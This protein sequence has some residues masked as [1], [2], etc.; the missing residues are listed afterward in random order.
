[1][2]AVRSKELN[3]AH[4]K[5][6]VLFKIKR[7]LTHVTRGKTPYKPRESNSLPRVK[8]LRTTQPWKCQKYETF[9]HLLPNDLSQY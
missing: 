8:Y 9:M 6:T 1:M 3:G 5:L 7:K 4:P 2:V